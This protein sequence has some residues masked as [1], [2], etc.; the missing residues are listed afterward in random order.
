MKKY[1]YIDEVI[2][3]KLLIILF[4]FNIPSTYVLIS[5]YDEYIFGDWKFSNLFS[6][7]YDRF[8]LVDL[9]ITLV[10]FAL[11]FF[12]LYSMFSNIINSKRNR[13]IADTFKNNGIKYSGKIIN[14]KK[15]SIKDF[16]DQD[17]YSREYKKFYKKSI[18]SCSNLMRSNIKYAIVKFNIKGKEKT[19]ITPALNFDTDKI[20]DKSVDVYILDDKYYV[21][22]YK[23]N[24]KK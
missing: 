2:D 21:D 9:I 15:L 3:I 16:Y 14:Y 6:N 20:S 17:D 23:L 24:E 12:V 13:T 22:N 5:M 18:F 19:I 4:I 1:Y 10:V 8:D 7:Y 11:F